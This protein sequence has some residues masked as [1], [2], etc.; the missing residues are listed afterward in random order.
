MAQPSSKLA[1]SIS[2]LEEPIAHFK[3]T[4]PKGRT[5]LNIPFEDLIC[6][7]A[8]DNYI[9]IYFRSDSG[10]QKRMERL[11]MKKVESLIEPAEQH[12]LRVHKSYLIN[13]QKVDAIQGK[14]QNYRLVLSE[15]DF[16]VPVSRRMA[17]HDFFPSI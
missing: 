16:Q 4:N 17:I 13:R 6:F 5:V 3:L 11:S 12:F 9:N 7:E 1:D 10:I 15:L 14:A 8:N 2:D